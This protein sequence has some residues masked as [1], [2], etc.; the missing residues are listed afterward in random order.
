MR[1]SVDGDEIKITAEQQI[2][3]DY[4][5]CRWADVAVECESEQLKELAFFAGEPDAYCFVDST[6]GEYVLSRGGSWSSG[7]GS[8]VF[9]AGLLSARSNSPAGIGGRSAYFRKHSTL[10]PDTLTV[11][12]ERDG[13]EAGA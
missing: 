10:N 2:K 12:R 6:E 3:D 1:V 11:E 13:K 7:A 4:S 5:G 8:G 9:Y